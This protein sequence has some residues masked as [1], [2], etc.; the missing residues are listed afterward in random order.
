M[1]YYKTLQQSNIESIKIEVLY[2]IET[3]QRKEN[4]P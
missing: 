1:T 3:A 4:L 2:S